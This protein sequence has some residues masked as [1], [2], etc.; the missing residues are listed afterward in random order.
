MEYVVKQV[1]RDFRVELDE[2]KEDREK[3]WAA[4]EADRT[5]I[6]NLLSE[7]REPPTRKLTAEDRP[8]GA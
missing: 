2:C 4:R 8:R 7:R 5:Q 1:Y 6:I 3:L